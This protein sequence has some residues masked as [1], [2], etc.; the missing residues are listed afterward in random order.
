MSRAL[1]I[2]STPEIRAKATKW[3][4]NVPDGTRVLFQEPMRSLDQ[5]SRL[6]AMLSDIAGQLE[7]HGQRLSADDW[8]LLFMNALNAEMR[9]VPAIDGK[10]FVALGRSTSKLSKQECSDLMALIEAFGALHG[11]KFGDTY[12]TAA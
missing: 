2:L 4:A 12:A 6:W 5:N 1:L 10:G 7:W 8:K 9:M 3:I 11:V